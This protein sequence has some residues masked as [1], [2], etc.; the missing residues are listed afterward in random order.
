M[1]KIIIASRN[2]VKINA[3]LQGF[4]DMFPDDT[5]TAEG[6][7]VMSGV[8][9]QPRNDMETY[10]GARNRADAA[11]KE[12][13]DAD[14]YV[15]L[16]GGIEEKED[17]MEAFAWIVIKSRDGGYGKARTGTF[18]LPPALKALIHQGKELG[19]ADDIVFG[20]TN[21]KQQNGTVGHLTSNAIDRTRYY[22]HAVTLALIPFKNKALYMAGYYTD[23]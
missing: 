23:Y 18:F 19:E 9:D 6:I 16:E 21:A 3:T 1:K 10:E 13:P 15:G 14:F 8:S 20:T 12:K 2:P 4:K 7:A 17:D 22:A 11:S 5:F